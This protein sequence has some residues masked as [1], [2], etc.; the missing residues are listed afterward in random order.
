DGIR[1]FHVTGVQTCALPIFQNHIRTC[2]ATGIKTIKYNMSLLGVVRTNRVPGRGDTL[3]DR[4][5]A[6]ESLAKNPP[7]TR[8]GVVNAEAFRS[9]ERRVGKEGGWSGSA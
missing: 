3:H 8:A 7:L 4:W 2:A 6:K 5:N 9:E 1:D